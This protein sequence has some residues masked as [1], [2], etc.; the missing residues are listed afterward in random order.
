LILTFNIGHFGEGSYQSITC[1]G[2][3]NPNNQDTEHKTQNNTIQSSH[4]EQQKRYW[5]ET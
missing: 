2:T 4:G 1:T 3:D 5:K